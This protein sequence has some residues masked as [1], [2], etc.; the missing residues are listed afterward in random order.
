VTGVI[1]GTEIYILEEN[2]NILSLFVATFT[3]TG[4][5]VRI[6]STPQVSGTTSN[7]YSETLSYVVTALD[8]S[9]KIYK[10]KLFAPQTVSSTN[11]KAWFKGNSLSLTNGGNGNLSYSN[12]TSS[13]A[14]GKRTVRN[15]SFF[16]VK[17]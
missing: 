13:M 6:G 5:S 16:E 10:V 7:S 12:P 15:D 1:A 4:K 17:S 3:T 11:L 9:E 2:V 8:E 14:L